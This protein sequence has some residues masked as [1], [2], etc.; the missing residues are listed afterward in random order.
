MGQHP[1]GEAFG[2]TFQAL[3]HDLIGLNGQA[4]SVTVSDR[5]GHPAMACAGELRGAVDVL[6]ADADDHEVLFFPLDDMGDTGFLVAQSAFDHA[7]WHGGVLHVELGGLMLMI[8][9]SE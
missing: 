7:A 4:V 5:D 9:P 8:E 1:G 2:V 6:G 3:L